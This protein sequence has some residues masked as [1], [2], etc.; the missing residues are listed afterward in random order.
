VLFVL[1]VVQ[2][3]PELNT[4]DIVLEDLITRVQTTKKTK[5]SG[6]SS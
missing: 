5:L 2:N 1:S 3:H 6:T 4:Q